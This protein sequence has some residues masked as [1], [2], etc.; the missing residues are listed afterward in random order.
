MTLRRTRRE[1]LPLAQV[2]REHVTAVSTSAAVTSSALWQSI[3]APV[4]R[5]PRKAVQHSYRL[6]APAVVTRGRPVGAWALPPV[7]PRRHPGSGE[8]Q[9]GASTSGSNTNVP[10]VGFREDHLRRT[11]SPDQATCRQQSARRRRPVVRGPVSW[12]HVEPVH[13]RS[14]RN[15]TARRR[16]AVGAQVLPVRI[17]SLSTGVQ[18]G[19]YFQA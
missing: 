19:Y 13:L 15:Q 17:I 16:D 14:R 18:S 9:P 1:P 11:Q 7:A 10:L 6:G 2:V 4:T 5:T 3:P 8:H 12:P